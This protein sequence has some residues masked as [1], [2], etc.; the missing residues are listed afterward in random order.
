[1]LLESYV[2]FFGDISINVLLQKNIPFYESLWFHR[3]SL[4]AFLSALVAIFIL[5]FKFKNANYISAVIIA[6]FIIY[7]LSLLG[8]LPIEESQRVFERKEYSNEAYGQF[9]EEIFRVLFY[10][11][12]SSLVYALIR[13]KPLT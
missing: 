7:S 10:I 5:I 9:I 4:I 2:L 11:F 6:L 1:M 8:G 3:Y 12:Q 13:S